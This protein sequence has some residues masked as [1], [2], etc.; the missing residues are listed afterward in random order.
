MSQPAVYGD[1]QVA[2]LIQSSGEYPVAIEA[3]EHPW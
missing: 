2:V 1:G 3:A